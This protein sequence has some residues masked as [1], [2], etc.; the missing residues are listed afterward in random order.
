M[1]TIAVCNQK[2]GVGKSTLT[3]HVAAALS[4][5]RTRVLLVDADPQGNLTFATTNKIPDDSIGLADVLSA[6][7]TVTV[8]ETTVPT[9]FEGVDL[10]PTVGEALAVVRDELVV[11]G[12]G[13]E[14]RLAE[15]L[16]SVQDNYD[17][18]LLDCPPSL[19]QLTINALTAADAA[20]IVTHARMWSSQGL[21]KLLTNLA[22]VQ[23]HYNPTLAVAGI[24]MNQVESNTTGARHWLTEVHA[25]AKAMDVPILY[26]EIPKRV[27]IADAVEQGR[28]LTGDLA[29]QFTTLANKITTSKE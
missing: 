25:F 8:E 28:S 7:T 27:A 21:A 9:I 3:Y 26:P 10:L 23:H 17:V 15:A 12:A 2:G 6:R 24:V 20:V 29:T 13:R 1:R 18:C 14:A 5:Q 19:D 22:L 11:A 16:R 4:Q